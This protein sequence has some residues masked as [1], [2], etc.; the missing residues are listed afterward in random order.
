[1]VLNGS[2]GSVSCSPNADG[3]YC[4]DVAAGVYSSKTS[5]KVADKFKLKKLPAE[6][7]EWSIALDD[8]FPMMKGMMLSL[9]YYNSPVS[10]EINFTQQAAG[11]VGKVCCFNGTPPTDSS[12]F[13]DMDSLSFHLD[14]L[15]YN[16]ALMK[17]IRDEIYGDGVLVV[18]DDI[19]STTT[20]MPA[21]D[22]ALIPT[23]ET[24]P[25]DVVREVMSAG[26][27]CKNILVQEQTEGNEL[28]SI[29]LTSA[30]SNYTAVPTITIT[31]TTGR[32]ASAIVSSLKGSPLDGTFVVGSGGSGYSSP[33]TLA[34]STPTGN[35]PVQATA[36]VVLTGTAVS[37][38][39]SVVVGNGYL[40]PPTFTFTGGGGTGAAASATTAGGSVE[41]DKISI[42]F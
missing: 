30:G 15:M 6:S 18:Y 40:S 37:G 13:Y 25:N 17:E 39:S 7:P 32:D 28:S 19:Q 42:V 31:S 5:G 8:M 2:C 20:S 22:P 4:V 16:D 14:Y 10:I 33:P 24:Y 9:Q 11:E 3:K 36:V 23:G 1:M 41:Q 21:I 29:T 12:T 34:I 38:F 26:L 27:N 35:N